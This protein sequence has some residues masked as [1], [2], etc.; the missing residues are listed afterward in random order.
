MLGS[1]VFPKHCI[2]IMISMVSVA[3]WQTLHNTLCCCAVSFAEGRIRTMAIPPEIL[4][5]I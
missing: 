4:V 3:E 1:N 5:S 2:G